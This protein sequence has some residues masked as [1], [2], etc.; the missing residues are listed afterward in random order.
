MA[1]WLIAFWL[2]EPMSDQF[3]KRLKFME[4]Q[5]IPVSVVVDA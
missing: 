2:A 5:T 1:A 3:V 4:P